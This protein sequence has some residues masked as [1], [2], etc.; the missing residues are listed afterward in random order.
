MNNLPLLMLQTHL[1]AILLEQDKHPAASHYIHL[2]YW[3]AHR[4]G[5]TM[6][7]APTGSALWNIIRKKETL[8]KALQLI[9]DE[10]NEPETRARAMEALEDI[11]VLAPPAKQEALPHMPPMPDPTG[12]PVEYGED[13][14]NEHYT[15]H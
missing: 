6:D 3:L 9:M 13:G 4:I 14:D 12:E 10:T 11:G 8:I 1:M 15:D 7:K 2:T 5:E